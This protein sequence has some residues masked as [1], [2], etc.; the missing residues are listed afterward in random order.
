MRSVGK[1]SGSSA[2]FIPHWEFS[3]EVAKAIV[4]T[5]PSF[6]CT[7]AVAGTLMAK[8]AHKKKQARPE[9]QLR[10]DEARQF[11]VDLV[12]L[13]EKT[14]VELKDYAV[15]PQVKGTAWE[16][17]SLAIA[18]TL[19]ARCRMKATDCRRLPGVSVR[20]VHILLVARIRSG[21]YLAD[22]QFG[23]RISRYRDALSSEP[24]VCARFAASLG[25]SEGMFEFV[26]CATITETF[27]GE[28]KDLITV[29][30]DWD[31]SING[32]RQPRLRPRRLP[33]TFGQ[34]GPAPRMPR[35]FGQ[36]GPPPW[37]RRIIERNR[38]RWKSRHTA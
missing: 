4:V 22:R 27:I 18:L 5:G 38:A 12:D 1:Q 26:P 9:A 17:A 37:V 25:I 31:S 16:L 30:R 10:D 29:Y 34:S 20:D 23:V 6:L 8:Q 14:T 32:P 7:V 3:L 36:G 35:T 2:L 24:S 13:V 28:V 21:Y 33:Q 15:P 19:D 11:A